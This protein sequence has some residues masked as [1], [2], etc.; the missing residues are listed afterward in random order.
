[1]RTFLLMITLCCLWLFTQPPS[2]WSHALPVRVEPRVGATVNVAPSNV[3]I[4]FDTPLNPAS[5]TLRV[6]D[7]KGLQVDRGDG[8][9]APSDARLLEVSLPPLPPGAYRVI[10]SVVGQDGHQTSGDYAFFIKAPD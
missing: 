1:M 2:G 7:A 9:A 3:R 5:S 8:P 4:W 10:W 6:F